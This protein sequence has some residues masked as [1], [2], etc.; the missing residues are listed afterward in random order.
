MLR[1]K[2]FLALS[3]YDDVVP[4]FLVHR[5]RVDSDNSSQ[6]S[7]LP[8]QIISA[9]LV[10]LGRLTPASNPGLPVHTLKN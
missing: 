5:W 2:L 7:T 6:G 9:C 1:L 10:L 3:G 4:G 8:R